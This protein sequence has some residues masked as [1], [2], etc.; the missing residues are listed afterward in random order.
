M[1]EITVTVTRQDWLSAH[2][3]RTNISGHCPVARAIARI[4]PL[5]T[6]ISVGPWDAGIGSTSYK[7]PNEL[8]VIVDAW[9]SFKDFPGE[10]TGTFV[11]Y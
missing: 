7:L 9:D 1:N 4:M 10:T 2:P 8:K 3:R 5:N 11:Q 6:K